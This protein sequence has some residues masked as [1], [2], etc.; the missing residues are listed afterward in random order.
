MRLINIIIALLLLTSTVYALGVEITP[1]SPNTD[2]NLICNYN[3]FTNGFIFNWFINGVYEKSGNP[4]ESFRTNVGDTIGCDAWMIMPGQDVYLG[5]ITTTIVNRAPVVSDIPD[6][7]MNEDTVYTFDLNIYV[8]DL[9]ND[10]ITWSVSGSVNLNVN[11]V[12][13]IVTITPNANWN[14]IENLLFTA[15]DPSNAADSDNV[16]VTVN[17]VNDAPVITNFNPI[18]SPVNVNEGS[19]QLFS[20]VAND[21]DGDPLTYDWRLDG[22]QVSTIASYNFNSID[23]PNAH[24]L[25]VTVSDGSLIA[26]NTWNINEVN[27]N[28]TV[29]VVNNGPITEGQSITV[30]IGVSDPG[31]LDTFTYSFD[32]DN[33][34]VYDIVDQAGNSASFTF[35]DSGVYTVGVRVRDDDNGLGYATTNVIVNN[36]LPIADA[37]GPY[38]CQLGNSINVI[39]SNIGY[40]GDAVI[41]SWDLDNDGAY[42]D[43][44]LQ[45]PTYNCI[46]LGVFTIG[47]MIV[48]DEG[49]VSTD[50][51]T[52]TVT[53][54]PVNNPPVV[55]I[56][57]PANGSIYVVGSNVI[58]TGTAVD[59]EDGVIS[60]LIQWTSSIDGVLG[61]GALININT[62]SL[63]THIITATI[64]DSGGL[65]D[66]DNIAVIIVTGATQCSDSLDNDGDGLTDLLDPGCVDNFDNDETNVGVTQC[67]DSFD[68]D[69]DGLIDYP[70]DPG[71][72]AAGDNDETNIGITQCSDGVDNDGDGLVDLLDPGCV[73]VNDNDE[74]NVGVTQCSDG[75]DNDGDGLI[76]LLDSG[77]TGAGDTNEQENPIASFTASSTNINELQSV[78]FNASGSSD[79]DGII[80]SYLWDF[81]DSTIGSGVFVNHI[82]TNAGIYNVTLTVTD[83]DGLT[84]IDSMIITVND[85]IPTVGGSSGSV[86]EV[87]HDF[88]VK[89]LKL[90]KGS[91]R[92]FVIFDLFNNGNVKEDLNV[93]IIVRDLSLV[94]SLGSYSLA[95]DSE[96]IIT[97]EVVLDLN[98][99]YNI[100]VRVYNNKGDVS[101]TIGYNSLNIY[102]DQIKYVGL[103]NQVSKIKE[104]SILSLVIWGLLVLL[105]LV[106]VILGFD[107]ALR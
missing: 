31:V 14:G 24:I 8:T 53:L 39:G 26:Q 96:R 105:M 59:P 76:D 61:S 60:N 22:V 66:T 75:L 7:N 92:L 77:C 70:N 40:A 4:L 36:V 20:V 43:S 69:G 54:L 89:N 17:P 49:G 38:S 95:K 2:D 100:E 47:L 10:P 103:N 48:D 67:S 63:G 97:G 57:S 15:R 51:S 32:W 106:L 5:T 85:V 25:T 19:S 65:Q 55:T 11:I 44:V 88:G 73:D 104:E 27:V 1:V 34:G 23:G 86:G 3:G 98:K 52:V 84:D 13:S 50:T 82:Y 102:E 91:D 93:E 46:S 42:D 94:N 58:F 101:E 99:N 90:V 16:V 68:N 21:I 33:D 35:A 6:I 18:N 71:C 72:T 37:D 62:L 81:G 79:I 9:D 78:S 28:P 74:T 87:K 64:T 83:N 29:A 41:Y 12:G 45:N 107:Y 56:I 30:S 80:V